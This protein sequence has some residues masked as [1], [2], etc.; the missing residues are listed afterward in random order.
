M[1]MKFRTSYK[2]GTDSDAENFI[3]D[4]AER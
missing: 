3:K 1:D 4:C 2:I